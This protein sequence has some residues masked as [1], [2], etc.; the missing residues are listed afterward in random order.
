MTYVTL[1][2]KQKAYLLNKTVLPLAR[3]SFIYHTSNPSSQQ[4][5]K[6]TIFMLDLRHELIKLI[7]VGFGLQASGIKSA[8]GLTA[9]AGK[10][11]II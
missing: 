9:G 8:C 2:A 6:Q 4:N 3:H 7:C 1:Y 5:N 10:L 11:V